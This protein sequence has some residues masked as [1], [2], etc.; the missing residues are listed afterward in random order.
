LLPV[1]AVFHA[2]RY[3]PPVYASIVDYLEIAVRRHL[4]FG[5][6]RLYHLS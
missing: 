6:V 5:Q 3:A 1:P 4:Q 2:R